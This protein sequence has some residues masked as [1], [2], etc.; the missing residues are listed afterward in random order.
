MINLA[1]VET[2]IEKAAGAATTSTPSQTD[3]QG[4][5][6]EAIWQLKKNGYSES[7]IQG[8]SKQLRILVRYGADLY[9]P[10]SVKEV[11]AQQEKW[12][13]SS[14]LMAVNAYA[15]FANL[16]GIHWTPPKYKQERKLPFIPL[17]SEIDALI[18]SSSKKM[19]ALLQLLKET[20]MRVGEA[21]R[22]RWID[23]DLEHNVI[24][25]NEPEKNSQPRAFKI[26]ARLA[27]MLNVLPRINEYVFAGLKPRSAA[28]NMIYLRKR[29]AEK[30]QN[31]RILSIHLHSFRHWH[32]TMEYHRTKD[33]LH[34][35]KRLGHKRIENTLLYTQLIQFESDEYHSAV[36]ETTDEARKLIEAGFEYVCTHENSMH[37]RKR[38]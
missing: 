5:I 10:E 11:I 33:L 23:V 14:K 15:F 37:F 24:T 35:M 16:N 9:D 7:T 22:L 34:V 31:P 21:C 19:A 17:E 28:S 4:K 18:A 3:I 13:A 12:R 2:R 1:E 30:L 29:V 36:A 32:A 38:K 6:I 26:D 8:Y 27:G 25:M 20:G